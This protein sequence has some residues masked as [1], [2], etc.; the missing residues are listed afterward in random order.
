MARSVREQKAVVRLRGAWPGEHGKGQKR[1]GVASPLFGEERAERNEPASV[2]AGQKKAAENQNQIEEFASQTQPR[3]FNSNQSENSHG[4]ESPQ[5]HIIAEPTT[6]QRQDERTVD[7]APVRSFNQHKNLPD[8][9]KGREV[10]SA[11]CGWIEQAEV[12]SL[13]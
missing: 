9:H 12:V 4:W 5:V 2:L 8:E 13:G 11:V 10:V 7:T 1:R 3:G 6:Y